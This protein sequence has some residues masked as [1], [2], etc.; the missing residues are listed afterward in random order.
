MKTCSFS[1]LI[2]VGVGSLLLTANIASSQ[3]LFSDNFDLIGP[4]TVTTSGFSSGY[5]INGA[6]PNSAGQTEDF[7]VIFGFDYSAVTDAAVIPSAPNSSGGTTKGLYITAN[8]KDATSSVRA[9]VNIY[10]VDG[11]LAPLAFSGNYSLKFDM[12]LN[13]GRAVSLTASAE[14][15]LFGINH[16]GNATNM[17]FD[18]NP[19]TSD[20]LFFSVAANGVNGTTGNG[21]RDFGV[22][23]GEGA[24]FASN[25]TNGFAAGIGEP[26]NFDNIGGFLTLF[27][28]NS[29]FPN[30]PAGAPGERWVQGEVRQEGGFI[31]YLLNGTLIA[32]W[33]NTNSYTSGD[34]MLGYWDV[35]STVGNATNF[36][37]FDNIEVSVVPEP[38]VPALGGIGAGIM[39]LI[40]F[41]RR[42]RVLHETKATFA[43]TLR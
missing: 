16:S 18:A 26:A 20:G 21:I 39:G 30:I 31:S 22:H 11:S 32:G 24:T 27:P 9:G 40:I 8:K 1:A 6:I 37:V 10:P 2:A 13:W 41:L 4:T 34:I 5:R 43:K 14:Q 15:A 7:R 28:S 36:V 19:T 25:K 23:Q 3:I 33:A 17:Y 12:W 29:A 42:R 35:L 38:S